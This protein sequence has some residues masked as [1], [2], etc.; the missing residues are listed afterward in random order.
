[1]HL[2][3]WRQFANNLSKGFSEGPV[4]VALGRKD[5]VPVGAGPT[6][7]E[8]GVSLPKLLGCVMFVLVLY[9][10]CCGPLDGFWPSRI[11]AGGR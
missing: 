9:A 8:R 11:M 4:P 10:A 2:A 5:V 6:S 3:M 1:M 7:A